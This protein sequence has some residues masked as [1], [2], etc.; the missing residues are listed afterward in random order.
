MKRAI[1]AQNAPKAVGPYSHAVAAGGLIFL[2][3]QIPLDPATG[4]L[5]LGIAAQTER[6]LKNISAVLA[7]EELGF[8]DVIKT[9]VFL[10]D[11]GDFAVMNEIYAKYFAA[12]Y[13]ARSAV[14]VAAL[15]KGALIEIE[16]I[17]A[18]K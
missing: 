12:P 17:A 6:V 3:G 1:N 15:P 10:K 18:K 16:C 2:S 11:M 8:D 14:E 5:V 9:T 13:P 4:E 7:A